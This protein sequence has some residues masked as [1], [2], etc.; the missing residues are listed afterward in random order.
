MILN[1]KKKWKSISA[2]YFSSVAIDEDDLLWAW[3]ANI[4]GFLGRIDDIPEVSS[5]TLILPEKK[6]KSVSLGR[7]HLLALDMDGYMWE[8]ART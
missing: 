5:P 8:Y 4:D 1:F 6:W 7:Y 2:G 3:G